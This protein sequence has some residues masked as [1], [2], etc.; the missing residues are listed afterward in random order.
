MPGRF[1]LHLARLWRRRYA[2]SPMD[3]KF[4]SAGRAR[5]RPARPRLIICRSGKPARSASRQWAA[6]SPASKADASPDLGRR[7]RT[8]ASSGSERVLDEAA[9]QPIRYWPTPPDWVDAAGARRRHFIF[10]PGRCPALPD[11]K[12]VIA[13]YPWFGDWGRDTMICAAGTDPR[14]RPVR[15][16]RATIL[17][18]LRPLRRSRHAAQCLSGRRRHARL[19][20][21]RCDLVV[22]R[23]VARLYRG[24]RRRGGARRGLSGPRRDHRLASQTARATASRVDPADGLL[25]R[26][27]TRRPAHLDGCARSATGS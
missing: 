9:R 21:R 10:T 26:R 1:A 2:E 19:Q 24:E 12:S 23:G 20:H 7:A 5:A 22:H 6:L 14:H 4:R 13:G 18:D 16:A 8:P 3:R 17:R 11:G 15:H 27:R 25:Q